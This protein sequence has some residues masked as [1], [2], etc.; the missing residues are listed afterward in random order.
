MI[1]RATALSLAL[2]IGIGTIIPLSSHNAQAGAP[3]R[4]A[5][6]KKYRKYKKYSKRWWRAYHHSLR[7]RNASDARKRMLRLR[8]IRLANGR[9]LTP[10]PA[11]QTLTV[12]APEIQI[13]SLFILI[14]GKIKKV[15][16]GD[17][18]NIETKDGKVYLVRMLGVD[19][20]EMNLNFGEKSRKKLSDLI[21]GK[22]ATVI[23]RKMDSSK[24][25]IGTVYCGGEDINLRQIESGMAWYFRQNGYEPTAGDRK[26][27][28]QA[29]HKSRTQLKGMWE[30]KFKK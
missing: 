22:D 29:E 6:K 4:Y 17:T 15:F 23:V 3:K 12:T 26:L 21:L 27:Y 13:S 9:E 18:F 10:Q 8:R 30:N 14:E 1:F 24:R 7:R 5:H 20:P 11:S 28:E 16:D 19:A 2:L 25:Y